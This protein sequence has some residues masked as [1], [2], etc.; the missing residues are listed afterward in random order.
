MVKWFWRREQAVQ[1]LVY[2]TVNNW[3]YYAGYFLKALLPK[4][5]RSAVLELQEKQKQDCYSLFCGSS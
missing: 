2:Q 1:K 5:R 3:F 4:G